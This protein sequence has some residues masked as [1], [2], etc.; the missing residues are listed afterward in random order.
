MLTLVWPWVF[1]ALPLPLIIW[2]A[3]P[4]INT[5]LPAALKVPFFKAV[6]SIVQ[7]EKSLLANSTSLGLW[8]LI[9]TL[10]LIALSGPQWV[11]PPLPIERQGRN[12]MLALDLSGSMELNDFLLHGRPAS[13][14]AIV[15]QAAS[16]FV[17]DRPTDKI[18]L[19]LFGTQAYLQTPLTY[20]H[21]SLL[22]R[23]Q[24]ATVGLAGKTTS[25]GDALGLA[26][27]RLQSTPPKGRVIIL[28]TDGVNNSGVLD[29][30]KA[31]ELAASEGIKIYTIGLGADAEVRNDNSL[32]MAFNPELE[33][34][35]H[36][37]KEV[38][39]LSGGK[40]FRATDSESLHAI[41][42]TINQMEMVS[43]D[44]EPIRP[45]Y[46]YYPWPLGFAFLFTLYGLM[47]RM[48]KQMPWRLNLNSWIQRREDAY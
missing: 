12:I 29:P 1:L 6:S 28:L 23:I 19:I 14:L 30:L 16:Q 5:E 15:K 34:D 33:L 24:D 38:A 43:Q 31:A 39:R 17:K 47:Q 48:R 18:G 27:K 21:H 44:A 11:G 22:M 8:F 13:R 32:L 10:L 37:L 7:H 40:Y 36:T 26:T 42:K 25:I 2:F 46:D 9:W 41:Y 35:E 3:L 45:Q 20:D 4:R